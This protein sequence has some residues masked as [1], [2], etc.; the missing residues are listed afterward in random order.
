M[1]NRTLTFSVVLVAAIAAIDR[2]GAAGQQQQ[3]TQQQQPPPAGQAPQGRGQ[4]QGGRGGGGGRGI[5]VLAFEDRTGFESM[6]NGTSLAP[7]EEAFQEARKKA[8]EAQ[9]AQ[10]AGE[11]GRGG[12]AN[13]PPISRFQDWNGD[14]QFWRAENG[15]IVG[16]STPQKVVGPNTFLIWRGGTPGDFE[17][18][19]EV[20][21]N[22][23]NSGIQYRSKM[24]APNE[25]GGE[26]G[27]AWRLGGYQ[28]DMDFANQYPGILY[29]EGG[30]MF[31]A[32]RGKITYIAPDGTKSTIGQL[33]SAEALAATFKPGDWN[34]FHLI[35]RG[36]TL[37]H[38]INGHVTAVCVDDDLKGR[39]M[40]GLIGFQL[41]AG[42]PMKLEIRNVAIK[43]K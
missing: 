43:L 31:L 12:R 40:A 25:G 22:S 36:N 5:P 17:L 23:T 6:F 1:T 19:A 21:M 15:M 34:Q 26:R 32:E 10:P 41:H 2:L 33:E 20:R 37:V 16:E 27:H 29:E 8:A 13:M 39:A 14:P 38:I 11:R 18:K 9:A 30:R 42:P 24:L 4:G 3:Q 35:A 7:G 28:M